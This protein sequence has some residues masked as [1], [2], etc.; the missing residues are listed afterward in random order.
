MSAK[1]NN[2]KVAISKVKLP[3]NLLY[4]N[5]SAIEE[6]INSDVE[7]EF[8][9]ISQG[10]RDDNIEENI[11]KATNKEIN[12]DEEDASSGNENAEESG[13][14]LNSDSEDF[15]NTANK[16]PML[17][18]SK[19]KKNKKNPEKDIEAE[20]D[21][22]I[23]ESALSNDDEDETEVNKKIIGSKAK[24]KAMMNQA[25]Q[26]D[27][28][29]SVSKKSRIKKT[30]NKPGVKKGPGRPRKI[31]KKEPIPRKGISKIPSSD[32]GFIEFI[33]DMPLL[34]KKM[35]QHYKALAVAQIQVIFR[36][37]DIIF[38]AEDHYQKSKSYIK[39]DATKLN[40]Y[41]CRDILDIGVQ[42][43]DM[44]L[45]LNKIDKEYSSLILMSNI[46]STQRI[47]TIL[48]ENDMQIDETHSI[49]II[50]PLHKMENE[51]EFIDEDYAIKFQFPSK[52]FRKM[53]NDIK[54]MST[55]LSITQEDNESPLVF[56][57]LTANKKI[58]SK[59]T[60]K[61]S[62]K[63]KLESNLLD[64]DSFRVDIRID[65]IKPISASQIA[66]DVQIF[67]DEN[68]AFMTKAIIDN[69][70]VEIKTLT[71]IIDERPEEDD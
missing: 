34:I 58:H 8:D 55:Q 32:N 39:I 45:I 46:E 14:A 68:K 16:K 18:G 51:E 28:P 50:N 53:I 63:I 12:S 25:D 13:N 10:S 27:E 62:K 40:H 24:L 69:G 30:S 54:T 21:K 20:F 52:Y 64:G 19:V 71:E 43:K 70:T 59:H 48:L 3:N 56:E 38:Y 31:P 57:Y 44:E 22:V 41:Y 33:Y 2:K 23:L 35:F 42:S 49:D 11:P 4:K 15:E 9:N 66:D 67:V 65:Y 5:K 29:E 26:E 37:K 60:V 17:R 47:I 61:N 36:P 7:I 1:N 6:E